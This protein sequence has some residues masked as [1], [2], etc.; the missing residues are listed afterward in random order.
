M[1]QW[2]GRSRRKPT[3]GRLVLA[4]GKRRSEIASERQFALLGEPKRKHYRL[5]GGAGRRVRIL[6]DNMINVTDPAKGTTRRA[7]ALTVI[8]NPADPNYV[9]RNILTK[10]A[11]VETDAGQVRITS[12]PGQDGVLN[13]VLVG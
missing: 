2:H 3:G 9:R 5:R 11:V 13:G 10:G 4:R 6:L 1:A 7:K 8:S 12:R